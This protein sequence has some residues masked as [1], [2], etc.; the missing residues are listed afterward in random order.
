MP[1]NNS[2]S[3]AMPINIEDFTTEQQAT[4][5]SEIGVTTETVLALLAPTDLEVA[6]IG[7]T[8]GTGTALAPGRLT[9]NA[10]G[11]PVVHDNESNAEDLP[12]LV[13]SRSASAFAKKVGFT[14]GAVQTYKLADIPLKANELTNGKILH[15]IGQVR[16]SWLATIPTTPDIT[17]VLCK[18]GQDPAVDGIRLTIAV[19]T[20]SEI[21]SFHTPM[22]VGASI[23]TWTIADYVSAPTG[24]AQRNSA[25][26]ITHVG[27]WEAFADYNEISSLTGTA[28]APVVL[29]LHLRT[30][31]ASTTGGQVLLVSGNFA[32][33]VS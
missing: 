32:T 25:G 11:D 4:F 1:V 33:V 19:A 22:I 29:E 8:D 10:A 18:Q 23:S 31:N 14:S 28:G 16:A 6:S 12:Y 30:S 17:L 27:V 21:I 2:L 9:L 13:N 15:F 20:T 7:L 5:R 26:T 24:I 3:N